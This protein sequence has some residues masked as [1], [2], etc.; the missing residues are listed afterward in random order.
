MAAAAARADVI[1]HRDRLRSACASRAARD[2]QVLFVEWLL[3]Q[4]KIERIELRQVIGVA[5]RVGGV[6]VDLKQ[7]IVAEPF[8]NCG[9]RLDIPTGLNLELDPQYPAVT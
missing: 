6:R 8:T 7:Q 4:E 3:D 5:E 1:D 2:E 9:H